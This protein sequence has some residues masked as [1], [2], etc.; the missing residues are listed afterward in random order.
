MRVEGRPVL[1]LSLDSDRKLAD[2]LR[3]YNDME[4][5]W[6]ILDRY[7]KTHTVV[8]D[9]NMAIEWKSPLSR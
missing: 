1:D 2:E 4:P 3:G 9:D 7:E 5:A 8:T 6:S